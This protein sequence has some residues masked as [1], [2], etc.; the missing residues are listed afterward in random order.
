MNKHIA[1]FRKVKSIDSKIGFIVLSAVFFRVLS[2]VLTLY[3]SK[4]IISMMIEGLALQIMLSRVGGYVLLIALSLIMNSIINLYLSLNVNNN[5]RMGVLP[6]LTS[7]ILD[8]DYQLFEDEQV[9]S[10]RQ[11]AQETSNDNNSLF[12]IYVQHLCD[13]LTSVSQIIIYSSLF[14]LVD[15]SILFILALMVVVLSFYR[16][17]QNK[18][19]LKTKPALDKVSDQL[20]YMERIS[21]QFSMAKDMRIYGVKNWF[22]SIQE[23][24][25]NKKQSIILGRLK[26]L[27][28]G[29]GITTLFSVLISGVGYWTLINGVINQSLSVDEFVLLFGAISQLTSISSLIVDQI[30]N[31]QKDKQE[32]LV[33]E[34]YLNYPMMF[35]HGESLE[36]PQEDIEITFE[37]VSFSYPGSQKAV[38]EDLSFTIDKN[39]KCALVGLNGSGKTT[40]VKLLCN[41]YKPDSGKILINGI[42][43]QKFNVKEYYTLFSAVFQD[44]HVWPYTIAELIVM[45]QVYD[46]HKYHEALRLSGMDEIID[47]APNGDQTLIASSVDESAIS[48]SGGQMQ[49]L[50]LAQAL[51]KDGHVLILDEPT[52]ALDPLAESNIYQNYFELSKDKT[53]LFITHRLASTQFCD[54]IMYLENGKII[55]D[56][57]HQEL[58]NQQG[59]YYEMFEKQSYY[60]RLESKAHVV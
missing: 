29:N 8:Y 48:L 40:L 15:Q 26:V 35:N 33:Y 37:N 23:E 55:E 38:F 14:L 49:K 28:G 53:S 39:Q 12:G 5:I 60:Y 45:G 21:G 58:M 42:D 25:F 56:G 44:V 51:Y 24:L 27:T 4:L 30:A 1:L 41:L 43:N 32:F 3:L 22:S 11:Q 19:T 17:Y 34:E 52:S 31:L 50:K 13:F 9:V 47:N 16:Q 18:Y 6:E 20:N 46:E 54:R 2:G 10:L 7:T 57:S 59:S 36:L